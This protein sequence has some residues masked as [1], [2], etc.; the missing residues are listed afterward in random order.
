[1]SGPLHEFL[2]RDH[3]RLDGLLFRADTGPA[4]DFDAYQSFRGG[5]LRHI[6]MEEKVLLPEARRL[7]N[8]QPIELAKQLRAD[9]A[10]LAALLVPSPTRE[11][12]ETV[13]N[14]LAEHNPLEENAGGFYEICEQL[15]GVEADVLLV[16]VK[17]LPEVPLARH[18]DGPRAHANVENLLRARAALRR[19]P[20]GSR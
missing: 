6:A 19:S 16:R 12:V 7:R 8:G 17:A 20:L 4:I 18:F 5:L 2:R 9:H 13:R 14:V 11:I 10:A 3:Q 1:M 15:A